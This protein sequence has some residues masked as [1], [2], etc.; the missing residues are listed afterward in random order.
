MPGDSVQLRT[1]RKVI[2]IAGGVDPLA[3]HLGM[4]PGFLRAWL[5][6]RVAMPTDY[7]LKLVDVVMSDRLEQVSEEDSS[8]RSL[9]S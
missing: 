6:G 1:L 8:V 3:Q 7:F 2:T 4:S 5:D 9:P